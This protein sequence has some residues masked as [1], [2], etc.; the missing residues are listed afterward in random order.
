MRA[1]KG[2][3]SERV[4]RAFKAGCDVVLHCSGD[5]SEMQEIAPFVPPLGSRAVDRIK[6]SFAAIG[7][8]RDI[9]NSFSIT[10]AEEELR[11]ILQRLS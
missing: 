7:V 6:Q 2:P 10:H 5:L 1:L 8:S 4:N 9:E 11:E 3:L